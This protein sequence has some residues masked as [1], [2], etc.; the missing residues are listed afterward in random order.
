MD[1]TPVLKL[2]KQRTA[3]IELSDTDWDSFALNGG[4]ASIVEPYVQQSEC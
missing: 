2:K 3:C 1:S 4:G